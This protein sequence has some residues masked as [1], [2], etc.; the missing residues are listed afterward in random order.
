ML[1]DK[2]WGWVMMLLCLIAAVILT[3]SNINGDAVL[4][5]YSLIFWF[6]FAG[7]AYFNFGDFNDND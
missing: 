1:F 7:F 3:T 2:F 5:C 4:T 6:A